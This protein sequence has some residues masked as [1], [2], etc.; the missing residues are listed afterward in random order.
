[1]LSLRWVSPLQSTAN[2]A[3]PG[4]AK[5]VWWRYVHDVTLSA[6]SRQ[7]REPC[8]HPA[9]SA[10][11]REGQNEQCWWS[12]I[13]CYRRLWD[14]SNYHRRKPGVWHMVTAS[15]LQRL[16]CR[17]RRVGNAAQVSIPDKT[18][19]ELLGGQPGGLLSMCAGDFVEVRDMTARVRVRF[20][21][22]VRV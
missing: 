7:E 6:A 21:V 5:H 9:I 10:V 14:M 18:A 19:A 12:A 4:A 15:S 20:G 8:G 1:M 22:R 3:V 2:K 11:L 16:T 13:C 17:S